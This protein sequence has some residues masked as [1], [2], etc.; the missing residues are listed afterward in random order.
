M[1]DYFPL[2]LAVGESFCNRIAEL[3]HLSNN[4]QKG[5]PSL[6]ISPRRYGKSSLALQTFCKLKLPFAWI[7]MF[8]V[9]DETDIEHCILRGVGKLITHLESTP[10]KALKLATELFSGLH[11][12]LIV[13]GVALDV[14]LKTPSKKSEETIHA[15][16]ERIHEFAA[17]V[18]KKLILFFDEFQKVAEVSSSLA[19]EAVLRQFA[20][21]PSNIAFIFSGSHRH[22]LQQMFEDRNRPFYHLCDHISLPRIS[23]EAYEKYIQYA[24]KQTWKTKLSEGVISNILLYTQRHPYYVNVL[25]S[26]LWKEKPPQV[27]D[28]EKTWMEYS[29]EERSNVAAELD[30]LSL[31]QRKLLTMLSRHMGIQSPRSHEFEQKVKMP[32]TSITQAL[33]FLESKDYIFRDQAGTI[34]VLDPLIQSVLSDGSL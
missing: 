8:S 30:L 24:A 33:H 19:L 17:K 10:K 21:L 27:A 3:E 32:G 31:N 29:M 7:D 4:V 1:A 34:H 18:N 25:C 6:I 13:H 22:L 15:V 23:E 14:E 28:V 16:L 5:K 2:T 20:Q 9:V 26:R 12:R 11:I